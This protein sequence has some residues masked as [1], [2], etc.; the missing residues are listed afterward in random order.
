MSCVGAVRPRMTVVPRCSAVPHDVRLMCSDSE[1]SE[2]DILPM[3]DVNPISGHAVC[4]AQLDDFD[5]ELPDYVPDSSLSG[6]D[7]EVELMDLNQDIHVLPDVFPVTPVGAA[8]VPRSL[9]AITEFVPQAIIEKEADRLVVPHINDLHLPVMSG[10]D[11]EVGL[12]EMAVPW[13]LPAVEES[14]HNVV[15]EKEAAPVV[16]LFADEM[17][18]RVT[19][20]D[21]IR[22]GSDL[23]ITLLDPEHERSPVISARGSAG[24]T[25]LPTISEVFSSAVLI[26]GG[27]SC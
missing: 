25:S 22:D 26:G 10:R 21:L 16:V 27:G 11:I 1:E 13:P 9:Q 7:I 14:V 20:I 5:W 18:V 19:L 3:R 8:A 6:R 24:P 2:D 17:T 12:T 23:P 4:C 15:L